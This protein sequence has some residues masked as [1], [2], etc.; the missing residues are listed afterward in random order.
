MKQ[1]ACGQQYPDMSPLQLTQSLLLVSVTDQ[2]KGLPLKRH[3]AKQ[4][5]KRVFLY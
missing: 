2:G 5:A 3:T 1:L 4:I